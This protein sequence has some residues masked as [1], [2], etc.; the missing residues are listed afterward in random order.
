[1]KGI[2]CAAA[3]SVTT[4]PKRDATCAIKRTSAGLLSLLTPCSAQAHICLG[5]KRTGPAES[6]PRTNAE[7]APISTGERDGSGAAF[8]L[9]IQRHSTGSDYRNRDCPPKY[10]LCGSSLRTSDTGSPNT[11]H[12][13]LSRSPRTTGNCKPELAVN[14]QSRQQK[15]RRQLESRESSSVSM[16]DAITNTERPVSI[17]C[18]HHWPLASWP[19]SQSSPGLSRWP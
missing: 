4:N 16:L 10:C 7:R 5:P 3:F 12:L 2:S 11:N 18:R 6:S 19:R 9:R 13:C 15:Q 17:R 1:M 8:A 14:Q